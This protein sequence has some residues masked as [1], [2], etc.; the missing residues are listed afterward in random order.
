MRASEER[1]IRS[2]RWHLDVMRTH[3]K[4][5]GGVI[6][7]G[8]GDSIFA[9]FD[10]AH[11]ATICACAIQ[12]RE[13]PP[14]PLYD[15]KFRIG[16]HLGDVVEISGDQHGDSVNTAARL[17]PLAIPGGICVSRSIFDALRGSG[18]FAFE[19]IGTPEL[20]NLGADL[21]V[22]RVEAIGP[23]SEA[24]IERAPPA[25]VVDLE[26]EPEPDPPI[27]APVVLTDPPLPMPTHEPAPA[28]DPLVAPVVAVLPFASISEREDMA[29]LADCFA[30]ELIGFLTRFRSLDVIAR[31]S[32]ASAGMAALRPSDIGEQL[33]VRYLVQ[34]RI[35]LS[36]SRI[37]VKV[38]LVQTASE[39]V[40]WTED[41]D[42][43]F[44][45]IFDVQEDI[46]Q[47][48]VAAMAVQIEEFERR[49]VR[50]RRPDSLDAYALQLQAREA[51]F[52]TAPD[53]SAKARNL[54]EQAI[55]LSP[56]YGRAHAV[57]SRTLSLSWKYGWSDEPEASFSD[58]HDAAMRAVSFD[59]N[60]ARGLAE[61]GFVTLYRREH[62]RSLAS[63][64]RAI[65]LNPS[66]AD[67]IAEYADSLKHA[68][69]KTKAIELFE[70]A[71]RLNPYHRDGY[72]RDLAHTYFV[73][74]QF[75]RAIETIRSM[76]NPHMALRVLTASY[77]HLGREKEA[78]QAADVLRAQHPDF[79]A[80]AWADI[81]PDRDSADTELLVEG[82][83]IAGL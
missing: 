11:D 53:M 48:A 55:A 41:Y 60:D 83:R 31:G 45:D 71:I 3:V 36:S 15:I 35:R 79:S 37:R 22:F 42:R 74:R 9:S 50:E 21:E 54:A 19:A 23:I 63:F 58:A 12:A 7:G 82:L 64:A 34:G 26:P 47:Q 29:A 28:E 69:E 40:V 72:A 8:A 6:H 52:W 33:N 46:A 68:G 65:E 70:R 73:D 78:K 4:N 67:I 24:Q 39:H 57:L 20:K 77:S 56:D 30:D 1:A 66:D 62:D 38:Q 44:D 76:T 49:L 5:Y 25:P 51:T 75:D 80:S 81:V 61:L 16:L 32:T 17:E 27:A 2:L 43:N 10:S 14:E 59:R 18:A 13:P